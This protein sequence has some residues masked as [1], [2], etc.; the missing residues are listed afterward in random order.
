M[1]KQKLDAPK[2]T[3]GINDFPI[4][5]Y[6]IVEVLNIYWLRLRVSWNYNAAK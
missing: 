3:H 1:Q 5:K 4:Y 6:N 2:Q